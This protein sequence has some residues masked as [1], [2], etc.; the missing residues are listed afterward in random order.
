MAITAS[1]ARLTIL[2]RAAQGSITDRL[3]P[4]AAVGAVESAELLETLR[5]E[6]ERRTRPGGEDGARARNPRTLAPTP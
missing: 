1:A 4:L 5:I 3:Q 2:H 6:D